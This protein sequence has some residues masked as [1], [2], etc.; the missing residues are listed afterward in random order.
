MRNINDLDHFVLAEG[1]TLILRCK[2][3]LSDEQLADA[4]GLIESV[5]PGRPVIVLPPEIEV[6]AG[7][8]EVFGAEEQAQSEADQ[9]TQ[10]QVHRDIIERSY[11]D[12]KTIYVMDPAN[13]ERWYVH[14][15]AN[16]T[17]FNWDRY[18]YSLTTRFPPD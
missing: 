14:H 5:L 15:T 18:K 17:T 9:E 11:H 12:G 8:L 13:N 3:P 16:P 6:M 2:V 4:R 7:K 10:E 1:E